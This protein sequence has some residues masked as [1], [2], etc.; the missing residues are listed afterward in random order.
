[1][2]KRGFD[3]ALSLFG[4]IVLSPLMLTVALLI[5]LEDGGPVFF[6]QRRLGRGN[7]FFGMY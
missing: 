4:L 2:L 3:L 7:R 1:V 6:V 5:K